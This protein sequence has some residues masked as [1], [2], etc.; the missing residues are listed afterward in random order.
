MRVTFPAASPLDQ[1]GEKYAFDGQLRKIQ[2]YETGYGEN[3]YTAA[4]EGLG[5]QSYRTLAA[6]AAYMVERYGSPQ[7]ARIVEIGAG[8]GLSTEALSL[9]GF[10]PVVAV[11]TGYARDAALRHRPGLFA[12]YLTD[13]SV[14][15]LAVREQIQRGRMNMLAAAGAIGFNHVSIEQFKNIW[16]AFR[17]GSFLALT[18][19]PT[20]AEFSD[21]LQSSEFQTGTQLLPASNG[22]VGSNVFHRYRVH[23]LTESNPVGIHYTLVLARKRSMPLAVDEVERRTFGQQLQAT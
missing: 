18:I 11:D 12:G 3:S 8:D 10:P 2:D 21:Y 5:Y 14:E 7:A 15:A 9:Y 17:P 1:D 4:L 16:G 22:I 23:E 20:G 19:S 13:L 6:E